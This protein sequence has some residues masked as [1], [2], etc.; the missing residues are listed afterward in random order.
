MTPKLVGIQWFL[1][2]QMNLSNKGVLVFSLHDFIPPPD[3]RWWGASITEFPRGGGGGG[4]GV[5]ENTQSIC[6]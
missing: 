1:V 2:T 4:G 5:A 6:F 3:F